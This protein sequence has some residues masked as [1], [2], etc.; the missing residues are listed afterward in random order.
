M[1]DLRLTLDILSGAWQAQVDANLGVIST[2]STRAMT[3]AV[4][5]A[6]SEGRA[7]IAAAGFSRRW[8]N[9]LRGDVYPNEGLN[10]A[11]VIRHVIPYAGVFEDGTTITGNPYLWLRLR[12]TPAKVNRK[13]LTPERYEEEVG[14]LTYFRSKR[15][16][17]LLGARVR[18]ARG[19][20]EP[21]AKITLGMLRKGA[22][23]PTGRLVTIPLFHAVRQTT[24][25]RKF[26]VS[27]ACALARDNL[28]KYYAKAFDEVAPNG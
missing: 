6:K 25:R 23:R 14:D 13:D 4:N 5:V 10:A 1:K 9:T 12:S 18:L 27:E 16:K 28:P 2:V 19:K 17:P 24:I 3:T 26:S 20:T 8:Q 21:P 22:M 7:S 15:G 11:G